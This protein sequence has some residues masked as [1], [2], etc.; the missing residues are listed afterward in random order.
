VVVL[1]VIDCRNT[2][3][4]LSTGAITKSSGTRTI[5]DSDQLRRRLPTRHHQSTLQPDSIVFLSSEQFYSLSRGLSGGR[6]FAHL[7]LPIAFSGWESRQCV[8]LSFSALAAV[9]SRP[10]LAQP[11]S[12][13]TNNSAALPIISL[14][15][16]GTAHHDIRHR[17][18]D[19]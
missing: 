10:R 2:Q 14:R 6:P 17:S 9:D 1:V 18:G 12:A 3:S 4:L 15:R 5:T 19:S 13:S 8:D 7:I 16:S 11:S